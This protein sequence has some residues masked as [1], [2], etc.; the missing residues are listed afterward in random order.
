MVSVEPAYLARLLIESLEVAEAASCSSVPISCSGS[1]EARGVHGTRLVQ[2]GDADARLDGL[3]LK[4]VWM[5]ERLIISGGFILE[6]VGKI[7]NLK[8][9]P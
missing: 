7:K 9:T 1:G 6:T 3:I 8:K 5:D 4:D 2:W